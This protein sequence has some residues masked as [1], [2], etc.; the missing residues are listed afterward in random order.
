MLPW[1][2]LIV[3]FLLGSLMALA[4]APGALAA[5]PSSGPSAPLEP[6]YGL[7]NVDGN[8]GEW[9]AEDYVA[10]LYRD[11]DPEGVVEAKLYLR[12]HCDTQ[13]MYVLVLAEP[14]SP[15]KIWTTDTFR[16]GSFVAA[17]G[18]QRLNGSTDDDGTPP[19][20]R[21]VTM[22]GNYAVGWEA[23][24][25]L[26]EGIHTLDVQTK[27]R[28]FEH[29]AN[30]TAGIAG[31]ALSVGMRCTPLSISGHK[32]DAESSAGVP[33]WPMT[34]ERWGDDA[35]A[36]VAETATDAD[37][38]YHFTGVEPARYRVV[39]GQVAGWLAVEPAEG[40]IEVDLTD[41]WAGVGDVDFTNRH[42]GSIAGC[43]WADWDRDGVRDAE[44]P[45]LGG[46]TVEV[47]DDEG[48]PVATALTDDAGCYRIEGL[49]PGTYGVREQLPAGWYPTVQLVNGAA[50]G[51]RSDAQSAPVEVIAGGEAE[52]SFGNALATLLAVYAASPEVIPEPSGP[53][54]F[55]VLVYNPGL[56]EITVLG[57]SDGDY[58]DL[59]DPNNPLLEST[60]CTELPKLPGG[61]WFN[62]QVVAP[63][64]GN[65]GD[66]HSG[67]ITATG[68]DARGNPLTA[69]AMTTVTVSD[70]LPAITAARVPSPAS[71]PE[72]GGLVTHVISV[73]NN[74]VEP[75]TL[76]SLADT[77]QGSLHGQGSCALPVPLGV[78]QTYECSFEVPITGNPGDSFAYDLAA[79]AR[80]DEG[81]V[82]SGSALVSVGITDVSS[83][84]AVT[85][86]PSVASVPWPGEM[87]EF[88][89]RVN[90]TSPTDTVSLTAL[91]DDRFG[92]IADPDN[93]LL[94][95]TTCSLPQE[96]Q[97]GAYYQC[98][99]M[100]S[101]E[102]APGS[103]QDHTVCAKGTDDDGEAVEVNAVASVEIEPVWLE[104]TPANAV[105]YL[106]K[107][108]TCALFEAQVLSGPEDS[109]APLERAGLPVGFVLSAD[110][111]ASFL[112]DDGDGVLL[113]HTDAEGRASVTA[114][115]AQAGTAEVT[116]WVDLDADGA[117]GPEPSA[118][119]RAA[120]LTG[121]LAMAKSASA[122]AVY[123]GGEVTY[124]YELANTLPAPQGDADFPTALTVQSV[125]DEG[126]APVVAVKA[127]G[128]NAGDSNGNDALDPGEV[129][130]YRCVTALADDANS[131]ATAVAVDS[132]GN[133][134][135]ATAWASVDVIHPAIALSQVADPERVCIGE[136]VQ[137]T[138]K[139]ANVGD[140]PIH[141][142]VVS[143]SLGLDL[144]GPGGDS[145]GDGLLDPDETWVYTGTH[146]V[147]V[148]DYAVAPLTNT[149]SAVGQDSLGGSVQ[150]EDSAIVSI[151]SG[152]P[153]PMLNLAW[154]ELRADPDGVTH[155]WA[156]DM[157]HSV[158]GFRVY[159]GTESDRSRA[160]LVGQ[161]PALGPD[162][163]YLYRDLGLTPGTYYWWLVGVDGAGEEFVSLGPSS[164]SIESRAPGGYSVYLPLTMKP[165]Q[166]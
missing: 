100:A 129:W 71:V 166:F 92:D 154:W 38:A 80:D 83:S 78:A 54:E 11:A 18:T 119:A 135:T 160:V 125:L 43:L 102:G 9:R 128:H 40:Y 163:T 66:I 75:V 165:G 47:V 63:V 103:I 99:Y 86:W 44:E 27:V 89:V 10:D 8:R 148:A 46:W 108:Q 105:R 144:A 39:E 55:T 91:H 85:H 72:P 112:G 138:V 65:A 22:S 77:A 6:R 139:V 60:T 74:S 59:T 23:S 50:D 20:F 15:A 33:D 162:R 4:P 126:C 149:A 121:G 88:T 155:T 34:L 118:T 69:Y 82:A 153:A 116:G 21:W 161:V 145:D 111:G 87:V 98:T 109:A 24:F 16:A 13:T 146:T 17:D 96:L 93:D 164:L 143:D 7:A 68:R 94:A 123:E 147:T 52:V 142:L 25:T 29:F 104:V 150:A 158:A 67:I 136:T 14:E 36:Y 113:A 120:W 97:P 1:V 61:G 49:A 76:V 31:G 140:D 95:S 134:L 58:G 73:T 130:Q 90:N 141:G 53:V 64:S 156:T 132:L 157:E 124:R 159:R 131:A 114:C 101:V 81:N 19:D 137:F 5:P 152:T 2:L 151:E 62:C 30:Y 106:D 26:E 127:G 56:E 51:D 107:G 115:A 28:D 3:S 117:L 57:L 37:G 42:V 35:W 133:E 32:W 84:L 45:G 122:Q 48:A 79:E 70:V 110:N 12:Y 41:A